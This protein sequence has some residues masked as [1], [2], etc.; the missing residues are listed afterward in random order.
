MD[1]KTQG[2][3]PR[4][5]PRTQT[6]SEAKA[7]DQRHSR[8]RFPKKEKIRSSKVFSDERK[9]FKTFFRQSPEEEYKKGLHKFSA[10]FLAFSNK[11]SRSKNSAVL[12]PRTNF[13]E[14]EAS[15]PRTSKCVLEAKKNLLE[16][17]SSGIYFNKLLNFFV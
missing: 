7:K 3:R 11:I 8:K 9:V 5:R 15:R 10:R 4:T 13:R 6:K 2:S 16:D 1:S 17:S 14:L 12:D